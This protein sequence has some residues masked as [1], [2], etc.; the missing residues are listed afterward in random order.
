MKGTVDYAGGAAAGDFVGSKAGATA[1]AAGAGAGV[2]GLWDVTGDGG[3]GWALNL[4]QE[5][6][7]VTGVLKSPDGMELPVKGTFEGNALTLNVNA[8]AATGTVKGTLEDGKLKGSY[9]IGG[10]AGSWSATRK[11]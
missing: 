3:G 2:S 4:T 6:P 5:G 7:A 11:S 9:D 10:N 1:A 8:D